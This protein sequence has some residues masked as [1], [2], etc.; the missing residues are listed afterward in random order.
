M[1]KT[2]IMVGVYLLAAIVALVVTVP[3]GLLDLMLAINMALAFI[4][5]FTS[6]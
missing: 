4:S 6:S 2:D 3:S 5:L 1:K